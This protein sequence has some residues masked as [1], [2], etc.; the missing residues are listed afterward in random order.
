MVWDVATGLERF[1]IPH[2]ATVTQA[3]FSPDGHGLLTVSQDK[4]IRFWAEGHLLL[5]GQEMV[6]FVL[7]SR[8]PQNTLTSGERKR[9][10]LDWK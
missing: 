2:D 7:V 3:V 1:S 4:A 10:F 8:L 9:Y 5:A 6:E